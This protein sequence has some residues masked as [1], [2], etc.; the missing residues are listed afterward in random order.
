MRP[1]LHPSL[2]N[3]RFGDPVVYLETLFEKRAILFDL[4]DIA[5]LAPRKIIRIE[6]V[7]VS[8]AHIDHFFGFDRLLRILV[9]RA[10]ELH[11]YGPPGFVQRVHHKLQAYHWNLVDR[12]LDDLVF[13][14]TEI[15][16]S[17]ETR[18]ARF[19]L[20]NAFVREEAGHR[21]IAKGVIYSEPMFQVST[22]VLE[23]RTPCLAYA[24]EEV[25]HVNVWK[26]RLAA[27]GLPVGPWLREL[28]QAVIENLPDD[29]VIHVGGSPRTD[30]GTAMPLGALRD[31]L[32]VT[33]GQKI[34]YVTDVADTPANRDAIIGLVRG[35]DVLFIEAAFSEADTA[36]AAERAHL[37]TAAA[38]SIAREAQVRRVEPFHFSP[39]YTGLEEGMRA[40]VM[41]AFA[42]GKGAIL[43]DHRGFS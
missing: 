4:G 8:H 20:K 42:E 18:T 33:P 15:D 13:I 2:V 10:K 28:K 29:H 17:L 23:H 24:I 37:T 43:P 40:E 11:L 36:L 3:G 12:Y 16:G 14:V 35:A 26:N 41:A 39:R 9:G 38:G 32:T 34:A 25:A 5:A 22:A 27:M 7:F 19:R 31:V 6:H 1:L 21:R 30:G